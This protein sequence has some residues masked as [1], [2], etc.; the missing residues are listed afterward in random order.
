MKIKSSKKRPL[1]NSGGKF[2]EELGFTQP[3]GST[4]MEDELEVLGKRTPLGASRKRQK[5]KGAL[6]LSSGS[7]RLSYISE[8]SPMYGLARQLQAANE[9]RHLQLN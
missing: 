1:I 2:R 6:N 9:A 5:K 7:S 8:P 4:T 3:S